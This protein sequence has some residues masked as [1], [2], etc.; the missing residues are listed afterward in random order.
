M[1]FP[2][3]TVIDRRLLL[4]VRMDPSAVQRLLPGG[5]R[6][7]LV[8]GAAVG[9]I[10]FLRLR[11]LRLAGLAVPSVITENAAHRFAI[12]R[13][14]AEGSEPSVYVPRRDTSSRVA[15]LLGGRLIEGELSR[16]KF[17]VNDTGSGLCISVAGRGGLEIQVSAHAA[18]S[19]S[20]LFRTVEEESQFYQDASLAYSPNRRR[21][22]IEAVGLESERWIGT[23]MRVEHFYSSW[24][25]DAAIF[26][27]GSWTLDSAML[28]RN[29]RAVWSPATA[30]PT[31]SECVGSPGRS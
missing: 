1:T 23:P 20:S 14:H 30:V 19:T 11:D 15:A 17:E 9:G 10:C 2:V 29:V 16:A 27:R 25:E 13:D 3:R 18:D 7:R 5:L 6:P 21:R 12:I 8:D 4:T 22:V 28:V 24:F 31:S 26:P